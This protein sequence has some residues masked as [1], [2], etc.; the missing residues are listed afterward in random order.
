[1]TGKE[2]FINQSDGEI[3]R[4]LRTKARQQSSALQKKSKKAL[5]K[6]LDMVM[7]MC[8]AQ[9][10]SK[11]EEFTVIRSYIA[12]IPEN[13]VQQLCGHYG[14]ASAKKVLQEFLEADVPC[15]PATLQRIVATIITDEDTFHDDMSSYGIEPLYSGRYNQFDNPAC[16][17]EVR[18]LLEKYI[19]QVD[20]N[21]R[22]RVTGYLARGSN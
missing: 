14:Y 19:E 15:S 16:K 20:D 7:D 18:Q 8:C 2:P 21:L 3:L 10:P 9:E 22:I 13:I 6:Y 11:R 4:I 12:N 5:Y 17:T 1:M